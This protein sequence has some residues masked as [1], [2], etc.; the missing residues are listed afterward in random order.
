[1]K[2][3][4]NH[5]TAHSLLQICA[6]S[7]LLAAV[8]SQIDQVTIC[9]V[10]GGGVPPQS[11]TISRQAARRHLRRHPD[12]QIG[13]CSSGG[14]EFGSCFHDDG[15]V[16]LES[17]GS[18]R[19]ADVEIGDRIKTVVDHHDLNQ[20]SNFSFSDVI[21]LLKES[22]SDTNKNVVKL[23]TASGK[24]IVMT[25]NHL[26]PTCASPEL[27]MAMELTVGDCVFTIDGIET[28]VETINAK[29]TGVRSVVTEHLFI[30]VD[31]SFARV[32]KGSKLDTTRRLSGI[33]PRGQSKLPYS[34]AM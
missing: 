3:R 15:I 21:L 16:I 18:K 31:Y 7:T 11:I 5:C 25:P 26:I 22:D 33:S 30:V 34:P 32:A 28:V 19:V 8:R 13:A 10:G 20:H 14:S 27:S 2:K 4:I 23:T 9:H 1:M 29:Y 12:D 17:G 6:A 24:T